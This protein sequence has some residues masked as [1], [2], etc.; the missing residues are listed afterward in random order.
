MR[1]WRNWG[2]RCCRGEEGVDPLPK[3]TNGAGTR[4]TENREW[5]PNKCNINY[6]S[7]NPKRDIQPMYVRGH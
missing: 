3:Q 2:C 5:R 7:Q 6:F 1:F 4:C